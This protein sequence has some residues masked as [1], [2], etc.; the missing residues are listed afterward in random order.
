MK[1]PL[2]LTFRVVQS[3]K[4]RGYCILGL[5]DLEQLYSH[6]HSEKEKV[7]LL[8]EFARAN[9][10]FVEVGPTLRTA[11][12]VSKHTPPAEN[13]PTST[14]HHAPEHTQ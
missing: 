12:L 14:E 8:H 13:P 7:Q 10:A 1:S 5:D 4:E 11:K 9:E 6:A 2:T 3:L